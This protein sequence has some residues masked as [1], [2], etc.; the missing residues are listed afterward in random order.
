MAEAAGKIEEAAAA[1]SAREENMM[2]KQRSFDRRVG[3]KN[4]E[5]KVEEEKEM[6]D[7]SK[8]GDG[9][10]WAWVSAR[11]VTL[12]WTQS[13]YCCVAETFGPFD[14]KADR[15]S[16]YLSVSCTPYA[17]VLGFI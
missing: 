11:K 4:E 5:V 2:M 15:G 9:V 14:D 16:P 3:R 7:E 6:R 10:V 12:C 13:S 17:P 8:K 1:K